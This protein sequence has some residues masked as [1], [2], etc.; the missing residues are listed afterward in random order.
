MQKNMI[1]KSC[2]HIHDE[3]KDFLHNEQYIIHDQRL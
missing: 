1:S 2:D 3:F